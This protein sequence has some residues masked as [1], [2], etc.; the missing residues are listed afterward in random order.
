M[1]NVMTKLRLPVSLLAA[2]LAAGALSDV[3][4]RIVD[5]G[6]L[7]G[8]YNQSSAYAMSSDGRVAGSR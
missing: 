8:G 4:Y 7:P 1:E 3:R 2:S 6:D 5:V